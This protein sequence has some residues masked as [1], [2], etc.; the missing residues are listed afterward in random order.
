MDARES[1]NALF[2][3]LI[4][5]VLFAALIFAVASSQTGVRSTMTQEQSRLL[6]S[7]MIQYGDSIRLVIDRMMRINGV[8]EL[9]SNSN[10]I[11]FS[12]NGA[13]ANYGVPGAQPATEI[14]HASGGGLTYHTPPEG[15]CTAACAYEFLGQIRVNGVGTATRYELAMI[16][17]D[18]APEVC[19]Q[20]N[21]LQQN[22]WSSVPLSGITFTPDRFDGTNYG[23]TGATDPATFA[24][25]FVGKRSFC[26][27]TPSGRM[28]F[29]H[30]LHAR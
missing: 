21:E 20:L 6:A 7:E 27:E 4:G 15:A 3:V 16:V 13:H 28:M 17:P 26:H 8:D 11:L 5:V 30:I 10:G 9:N 12:A 25:V 19:Q 24:G 23:D 22:G 1:G 14:F 29:V 2:L 18:I